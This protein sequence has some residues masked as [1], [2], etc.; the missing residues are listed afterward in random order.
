MAAALGGGPGTMRGGRRG[1]VRRWCSTGGATSTT[2]G[3]CRPP[4]ASELRAPDPP[5]AVACVPGTSAGAGRCD[6]PSLDSLCQAAIVTPAPTTTSAA[7]A[8]AAP[9]CRPPG[10]PRCPPGP[11]RGAAR[12]GRRRRARRPCACRTRPEEPARAASGSAA[13]PRAARRARRGSGRT[14]RGAPRAR[15]APPAEACRRSRRRARAGAHRRRRRLAGAGARPAAAG[16]RAPRAP[17]PWPR[18]AERDGDLVV[19][20][21]LEVAQR[22]RHALPRREAAVG[23]ADLAHVLGHGLGLGRPAVGVA[24]VGEDPRGRVEVARDV[25]RVEI[26]LGQIGERP[27]ER[28]LDQ[29]RGAHRAAG[30]PVADAVETPLVGG[31]EEL[32]RLA[33]AALDTAC[34]RAFVAQFAL[35][36]LVP[37]DRHRPLKGS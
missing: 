34:E 16:A 9:V 20:T 31:V 19:G 26:V 2:A 24:L 35:A 7:M 10:P 33:V 5:E 8:I 21:A 17:A 13:A 3:D 11:C 4:A 14:P 22:E 27:R 18:A 36:R 1:P 6:L 25:E 28:R 15:D 32:E 30:E 12:P 37:G 23:G 29:G